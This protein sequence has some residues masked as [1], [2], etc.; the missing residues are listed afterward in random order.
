MKYRVISKVK[1]VSHNMLTDR[2]QKYIEEKAAPPITPNTWVD[3]CR[4]YAEEKGYTVFFVIDRCYT[5]TDDGQMSAD[6]A[7]ITSFKPI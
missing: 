4:A 2:V 5:L 1:G 3:S 6:N 7:I